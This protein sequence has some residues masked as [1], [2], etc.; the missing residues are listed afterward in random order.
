MH[1]K[2][3]SLV[4]NAG[5]T[6]STINRVFIAQPDALKESLAGRLFV[7]AEIKGK[8]AE[9]EK[10]L[11]FLVNTI[12]ADYYGDEKILLRQK[13]ETIKVENIFESVLTKTN[14]SLVDFINEEKI[15][16]SQYSANL[17]VGVIYENKL[18]FSNL[19]KNKAL[20][21]YPRQD[22]FAVTNV[23]SGGE[24][25]TRPG[26]NGHLV[27]EPKFFSSVVSGEI[28][29]GS[30]F[31]FA[32][33]ALPEYLSPKEL[34]NIITKL[35]PIVA[36]E[37]IKNTLAQI[38]SYVPFLGIIIKNSFDQDLGDVEIYEKTVSAQAS[39]S[40]LNYTEEKTEK[41]LSPAG[42]ISLKKTGRGLS[43][44]AKS[45]FPASKPH[46]LSSR[47]QS[48]QEVQSEIHNHQTPL[49]MRIET[50][51]SRES[52][53]IKEKIF[54]RKKTINIWRPIKNGF[55][56]FILIF[57][58]TFFKQLSQRLKNS[59]RGLNRHR[60][61]LIIILGLC[62]L[63]LV[64]SLIGTNIRQKNKQAQTA[65]NDLITQIEDKQD[66]IDSYLLYNN[67]DAA[68]QVLSNIQD[69]LKTFPQKTKAE[70]AKYQ[71]LS[72]KV[73]TV[74]AR[75]QHLT[76]TD[77]GQEILKLG[78]IKAEASAANLLFFNNQLFIADN[79]NHNL[80]TFNTKSKANSTISLANTANLAKP[81]AYTNPGDKKDYLYYL[82]NQ[83][84]VK[85]D[86]KASTSQLIPVNLSGVKG[87][88]RDYKIFNSS[89][90]VL[91]GGNDQIFKLSLKNNIFDSPA[92]WL[93]DPVG[94]KDS[95]GFTI[96]GTIYVLNTNGSLIKL[97]KGQRQTLDLSPVSPPLTQATRLITG[98]K[99]FFIFEASSK[100]L[101]VFN[102][103]DIK[104]GS[105][106]SLK[107]GA[108]LA[109]FD[110]SAFTNL[111][112]IEVNEAEKSAYILDG[113]SIFQL[114]LNY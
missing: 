100:R 46:A 103:N 54:G 50:T 61:G 94:L 92:A 33:E 83:Q 8:R 49:P 37:Q 24:D 9:S 48:R 88:L 70:R 106:T 28:P 107:A 32:N 18:Y 31:V 91:S 47:E 35:P 65:Y 62:V 82:D 105:E 80:Y 81:S 66:Q 74:A 1:Y 93:K 51:G 72:A 38:N 60:R 110:L 58:G 99:Y 78:D 23:E 79:Q 90:Y 89:L 109:Q 86:L 12:N 4:L 39:I 102:K 113:N 43:R 14:K 22:R 34:T 104:K 77:K 7:L 56:N 98:T 59:F 41:M 52:F 71:D 36:A 101:A 45:L 69:L 55:Q 95:V 64:A 53:L 96:D 44:L 40:N 67:E 15:K 13:V 26:Q 63:V 111:K 76:K 73:A 25:E 84:L 97:Y 10:I 42:I 5:K 114:K 87:E 16:I 19:G 27:S 85:V 17:V 112:D 30:Y 20:L 3:A 29:A 2:I 6:P 11:S 75:V 21:I 57:S 68:R 108:F